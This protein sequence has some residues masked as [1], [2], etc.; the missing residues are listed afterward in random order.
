MPMRKAHIYPLA[1]VLSLVWGVVV[2]SCAVVGR[3]PAWR[4]HKEA[5]HQTGGCEILLF[6]DFVMLTLVRPFAHVQSFP[7][8]MHPDHE[9]EYAAWDTRRRGRG[10]GLTLSRREA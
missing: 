7:Y 8:G 1:I 5:L 6:S 4:W 10:S 3:V 2:A 9:A